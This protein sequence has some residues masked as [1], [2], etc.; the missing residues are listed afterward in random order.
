MRV[1]RFWT[2]M[3][4]VVVLVG[5]LAG[6]GSSSKSSRTT[7]ELEKGKPIVIGAPIDES[8]T[9]S[10]TDVPAL[11]AAQIEV[12]KIN[13]QGGVDGHRLVFDILNTHLKPSETR[14][15]ALALVDKG[16]AILW[17]T[18]DVDFATPSIQ[19]GLSARL[20]TVAPCVGTDQMGPKRFGPA[21][22]LAF[23]FG[24]AAQDEGA[25]FAQL[26]IQN[27]W[28]TAAVV[29]D[30]SVAFTQNEC[31]AFADR[32]AQLGGK[33]VHQETFTQGDH[34]IGGVVTRVSGLKVDT[35]AVCTYPS[36]AGDLTKFVSDLR[37]LG[38]TTP[39]VGPWALDG[40]F[41]LPKDPSLANDIWNVDYADINGHD[42]D[43][44]V[45]QLV[46]QLKAKGQAPETSSFVTGASAIDGLVSAIKQ[47]GGSVDGAKLAGILEGFQNV[48]TVGGKL[49]FSPAFHTVFGR[50]YR[51]IHVVNGKPHFVGLIRAKSPANIGG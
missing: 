7:G 15:D 47:A 22:K 29:T 25:A 17:V 35:I 3:S 27:G 4:C 8:S 48:G 10:I 6:C 49:S 31:Q 45:N 11:H 34:T 14:S 18:C 21:G 44:A 36:P 24:N 26:A 33:V 9:M 5:V 46:A 40:T 20:L 41:W 30:K 2:S 28:K 32:F 37:S 42:P 13:A 50:E 1:M 43:P 39:V 16:A 19:V 12:D 51:I 38:N 23:S